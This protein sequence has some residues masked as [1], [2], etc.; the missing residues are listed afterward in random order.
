M[1]V[2]CSATMPSVIRSVAMIFAFSGLPIQAIVPS[3][4]MSNSEPSTIDATTSVASQRRLPG[5]S[6]AAMPRKCMQATPAPSTRPP[7]I[8]A[9][10]SCT[11]VAISSAV[12]VST[13]ATAND[14]AV[15]SVW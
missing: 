5:T 15:R 1:A 9:C 12:V 3:A 6:R 14:R 4:P 2:K 13:I 10:R 11:Q 8:H 7:A